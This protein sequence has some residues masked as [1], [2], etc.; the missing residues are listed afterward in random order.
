MMKCPACGAID[1]RVIDSRLGKDNSVIRRRRQ[2]LVCKKRFTTYERIEEILPYVIKKDGRREAFD[3]WKIIEGMRRA[4]EKRPISIDRIEAV[5][6][7]IEQE[8]MERPEKEISVTYIG[9]RVMEELEQMDDIAYVRF[10]SVYRSFRDIEEFVKEIRELYELKEAQEQ[11]RSQSGP[12]D[13]ETQGIQDSPRSE[14]IHVPRPE[15]G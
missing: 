9:E 6:D 2:C 14:D 7:A 11:R 8:L 4:C 1:D 5:A 15:V 13:E 12:T 3:R 10:A